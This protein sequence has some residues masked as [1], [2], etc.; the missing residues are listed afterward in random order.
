MGK[1]IYKAMVK[2]N[3]IKPKKIKLRDDGTVTAVDE[4]IQVRNF[5]ESGSFIVERIGE[6]DKEKHHDVLRKIDG[7]LVDME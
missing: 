2:N 1:A 5:M 3:L 4:L 6:F 7:V